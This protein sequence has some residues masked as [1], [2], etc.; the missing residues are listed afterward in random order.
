VEGCLALLRWYSGREGRRGAT[1]STDPASTD[2]RHPPPRTRS[3]TLK[4]ETSLRS[5]LLGAVLHPLLAGGYLGWDDAMAVGAANRACHAEWVRHVEAEGRWTTMLAKLEALNGTNRCIMCTRLLLLKRNR[6]WCT[7]DQWEDECSR[8]TPDLVGCADIVLRSYLL[9]F[10]TGH[11]WGEA[12]YACRDQCTCG[13]P[14]S[15]D[16]ARTFLRADPRCQHGYGEEWT[17]YG[18]W[19]AMLAYSRLL[20][21]DRWRKFYCYYKEGRIATLRHGTATDPSDPW[22]LWWSYGSSA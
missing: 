20:L 3:A 19:G 12:P 9:P 13:A 16:F 15:Q 18:R 8:R 2:R 1:S 5:G 6:K 10:G 22:H 14:F 21:G 17:A 7:P 4:T 11:T